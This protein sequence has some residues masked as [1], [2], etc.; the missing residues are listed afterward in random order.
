MILVD[1]GD[2][3][4]MG[5]RRD[6]DHEHCT[7]L[8]ASTLEPLILPEPLVADGLYTVDSMMLADIARAADLA[9]LNLLSRD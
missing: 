5:N 2:V 8:L 4:A 7:E 9:A 6:D 3:V 1:T